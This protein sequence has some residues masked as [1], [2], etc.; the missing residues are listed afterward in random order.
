MVVQT[1]LLAVVGP[2]HQ[3]LLT[4]RM[5]II[6]PTIPGTVTVTLTIAAGNLGGAAPP[7]IIVTTSTSLT[8]WRLK[9]WISWWP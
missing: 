1:K 4:A 7:S 9:G 6:A 5:T 8:C 3:T 2:T